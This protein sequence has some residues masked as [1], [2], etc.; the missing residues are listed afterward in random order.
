MS[1]SEERNESEL[2]R[3]KDVIAEI[4]A[5][6]LELKKGALGLVRGLWPVAGIMK[7]SSRHGSEAA[8][9]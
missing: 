5:E 2:R 3:M 7:R 8:G 4:T 1:A 6:N 9:R